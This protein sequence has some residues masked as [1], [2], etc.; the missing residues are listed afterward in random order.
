MRKFLIALLTCITISLL[1]PTQALYAATDDSVYRIET[2]QFYGK[3]DVE[4]S[5]N[6][7]IADTGWWATYI[8]T[9]NKYDAYT[10]YSGGFVGK[11]TVESVLQQLITETNVYA[12]YEPIGPQ[13][14]YKKVISRSYVGEDYTKKV[15]N[16]FIQS[17]GLN[18]T[19]ERNNIPANKMKVLSGAFHGEEKVKQVLQDFQNLTGISATYIPF[20]DYKEG[21]KV[22]SG[23]FHGE[24]KVNEVLQDFQNITNISATYEPIEFESQYNF[25]S[26]GFHGESTVIQIVNEIEALIGIKGTYFLA[27]E[28]NQIYKIKFDGL[29]GDSLTKLTN[30]FEDKKWWYVLNPT[31]TKVPV[32]FRIV[33]NEMTDESQVQK[34][35][36]YFS[37]RKWWA[38]SIKTGNKYYEYFKIQTES[39]LEQD[40]I[41]KALNYFSERNWY[42]AAI[43]TNEVGYPYYSIIVDKLME[44]EDINKAESFFKNRNLWYYVENSDSYGYNTYRIVTQKIVNVADR[45]KVL[46]FFQ[47]RN[48]WA[49]HTRTVEDFYRIVTGGFVGYENALA[50]QKYMTEKYGWW[51]YLVLINPQIKYT[52]YNITIEQAL[53]MQMKV[54]PQTDKYKNSPAYVSSQY[55]ELLDGG[56]INASAGVNIRTEPKFGNNIY[57]TLGYGTAVLIVDKNVTGDPYNGSTLWY[58]IKYDGNDYYVHSSLVTLGAKVGRV[59]HDGVNVR[60]DKNTNSHIYGVVNKDRLLTIREIG[61]EWHQ[62]EYTTWRNAPREDVLYY[63]NPEN[64][65]ND[66]V[67]RFQFLDLSKPSGVSAN[68]LNKFLANKGVLAGHGQTFI[69]AGKAQ[70]INDLYLVAHAI[71]ETGN[72]TSELATGVMYNG[73]KVYNMFGIGAYDSNPIEG[74]AKF[75]Y[76]NGWFTVEAAIKGGAA[77]IGNSYIK[78]GQNTLYK[79]RWNPAAMEKYGYATKQYATDIGWASKQI[80]TLYNLY[81]EVGNYVLYLDVPV[82]K[83]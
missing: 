45:D 66:N 69:D 41:N 59:T 76:E 36:K 65:V 46:S 63:L 70:G 75:A 52:H 5:L 83:K 13:V 44:P 17:T 32:I 73:K 55:I 8:K 31:G 79:M 29:Y 40:K 28:L 18:A 6:R 80:I 14:P 3:E 56:Y 74:G 38:A 9:G 10:V 71:L 25:L 57:K 82:Y 34:A 64:F 48:W 53:E 24:A 62:V 50:S 42:A 60:A 4:K 49:T 37:D 47:K 78:A 81:Q 7:L 12:T 72:G 22:V 11:S 33:T 77:F 68:V 54:S 19:Y 67:Q 15:V 35:L 26:G 27:D 23:G 39:L 51:S 21:I 2:G 20:G 30:L 61:S 58:K 43:F 16:E 1:I